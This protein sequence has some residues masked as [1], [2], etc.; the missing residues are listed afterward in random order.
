MNIEPIP[1][2][3]SYLEFVSQLARLAEAMAVL[4]ERE[5]VAFTHLVSVLAAP[6]MISLPK[7]KR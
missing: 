2:H 4:E 3:S 7:E 5:S 6:R 1:M